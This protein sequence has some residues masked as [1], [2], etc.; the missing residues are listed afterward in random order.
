MRFFVCFVLSH[1]YYSTVLH[2]VRRLERIWICSIQIPFWL[3][4]W[5]IRLIRLFFPIMQKPF[6]GGFPAVITYQFGRT[7]VPG[8]RGVQKLHSTSVQNPHASRVGVYLHALHVLQGAA[9]P[10]SL[11]RPRWVGLQQW[12]TILS[13]TQWRSKQ[14]AFKGILLRRLNFSC[15]WWKLYELDPR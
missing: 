11:I 14:D 10:Y 13:Q 9:V 1:Y 3:I 15:A 12:T 8:R 6:L 5:L 2:C 7:E 4:D